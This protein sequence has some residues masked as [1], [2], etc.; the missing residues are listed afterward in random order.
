MDALV[1]QSSQELDH[2]F[3]T[4]GDAI[5]AVEGHRKARILSAL[6]P[7]VQPDAAR[8]KSMADW[9]ELPDVYVTSVRKVDGVFWEI[10]ACSVP[11]AIGPEVRLTIAKPQPDA[12]AIRKEALSDAISHARQTLVDAAHIYGGAKAS[13]MFTAETHVTAALYK[14]MNNTG[15]EIS[16][17]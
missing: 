16:H 10:T 6:E 3:P 9:S 14:L 5:A 8:G 11:M 15:K 1:D 12:A 2:A 4:R 7:A 17:E 13:A